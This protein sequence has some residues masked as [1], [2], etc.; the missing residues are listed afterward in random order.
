MWT[1]VSRTSLH[2]V[3]SVYHQINTAPVDLT[4]LEWMKILQAKRVFTNNNNTKRNRM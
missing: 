1:R 4:G 3:G 2:D